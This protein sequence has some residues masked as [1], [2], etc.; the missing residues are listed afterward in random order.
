MGKRV[1]FSARTVITVDPNLEWDDMGFRVVLRDRESDAGEGEWVHHWVMIKTT[2]DTA[3]I[4]LAVGIKV[5]NP[6]S[7]GKV[8]I[9]NMYVEEVQ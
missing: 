8:Y 4:H 2:E 9:D 6:K 1:N 5:K 3:F 7:T